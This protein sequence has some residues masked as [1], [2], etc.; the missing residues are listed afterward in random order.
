MSSF[1][2]PASLTLDSTS[3]ISSP[4]SSEVFDSVSSEIPDSVSSIPDLPDENIHE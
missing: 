2:L 4:V 3:P 1:S